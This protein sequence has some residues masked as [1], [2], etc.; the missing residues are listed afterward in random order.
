M[1]IRLLLTLAALAIG[2]ATPALAQLQNTVDPKVRQQIEAVTKRMEEAYNKHDAAAYAA[3]FTE[4]GIHVWSFQA[5]GA[6]DG[7]PAIKKKYE[8]VFA[9][10]PPPI[11]FKVVQVYAI[12]PKIVAVI[13][14]TDHHGVKGQAL[15][16]YVYVPDAD[17]WKVSLFYKG[18]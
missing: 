5:E 7:L 6:A 11:S 14:Y 4:F 12:G 13:D 17:D 8:A 9:N 1:K 3:F 16:I 10:R 15:V 18:L 2:L